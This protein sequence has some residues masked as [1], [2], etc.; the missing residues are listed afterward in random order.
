MTVIRHR[1]GSEPAGRDERSAPIVEAHDLC[2]LLGA[3]QA[4]REV[5]ISVAAGEVVAVM[6]SSGSGKSSLLHCL[7]GLLR[8]NSGTVCVDGVDLGGL[9]DRA[10]SR[11]RLERLG[12]VSQFGD[13]VPELTL[14]ENV[15]LPMRLLHRSGR[16]VRRDTGDLLER[17]GIAD[18]AERRAGEASGGQVQR[19][20]VARALAHQPP[21]VLADEPTGALDTVTGDRV[22]TAL[23]QQARDGGAAVLLVTHE[24]RVAAHADREVILR[25]G[26]VVD[27]EA[28]GFDS[29]HAA[30]LARR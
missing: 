29:S 26:T 21:I 2:L 19:A 13:L 4:L 18:V 1:A 11:L 14:R 22:L 7:A 10:R 8:P 28:V 6:G 30:R 27:D 24:A 9:S 15:E 16:A 20:A 5:S 17:M 3:T 12:F 25:D 23:L